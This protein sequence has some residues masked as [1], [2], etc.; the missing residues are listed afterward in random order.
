MK[1]LVMKLFSP[2]ILL[3]TMFFQG[4]T[5]FDLQ[6]AVIERHAVRHYLSAPISDETV[7]SLN[8][9]VRQINEKSGL[10]IQLIV[11]DPKAL[12]DFSLHMDASLVQRTILH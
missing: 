4:N 10:N 8:E 9:I 7:S 5:G 2:I 12:S 6:K 1:Y 3:F 11:N